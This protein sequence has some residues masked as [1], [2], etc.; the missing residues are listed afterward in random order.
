M[1][2]LAIMSLLEDRALVRD[3]LEDRGVSIYSETDIRGHSNESI[4]SYG[5]FATSTNETQYASLSFAIVP[6]EAASE[7]FAAI[8]ARQQQEPSH[9]PIRAFIVPVEQMV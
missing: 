9:H 4:A 3:L 1:K 2:L 6:D 8:A 7:V 5:W